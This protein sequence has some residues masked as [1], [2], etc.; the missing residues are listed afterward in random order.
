MKRMVV[1]STEGLV[2][3]IVDRQEARDVKSHWG[4]VHRYLRTGDPSTLW[5]LPATGVGVY[6]F[7]T[8]AQQLDSLSETGRFHPPDLYVE[9][10]DGS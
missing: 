9:D 4:A 1:L 5:E 7:E 6:L 3:I 2:W 10:D 8:D